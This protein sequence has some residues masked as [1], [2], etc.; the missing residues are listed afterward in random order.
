MILCHVITGLADGGAEA[1]LYRLCTFP[2]PGYRHI[3]VALGP[4]DK[5]APM[6][7][8]A[9]V[10]THCLGLPRGRLTLRAV[11]RMFKLL[12]QRK[13][14][15]VQTW[16]YHANL[17]GGVVARLA[18]CSN[19]VWGLHHTTLVSGTTGKSTQLV[20][21]LCARL[22][23][24][25]PSSIVACAQSARLVHEGYGY[26]RSKFV[27]V[28][29]GYETGKF[30]P[31][32][33]AG[34]AIRRELGIGLQA[35]VIGLVGRWHPDKDHPTLLAAFARV[36]GHF[37]DAQLLL[38]GT[39]CT[40]DNND[41]VAQIKDHGLDG[42]V[43]LLGRRSDVSAIM[44]AIDLHVLSSRS[45]AFPNVVAEAMACGTPCVVTDVGDASLIVGDTGWVV[46]PRNPEQLAGA[47]VKALRERSDFERWKARSHA[48]RQR[49]LNEFSLEKMVER[50]RRVWN[51][52]SA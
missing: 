51:S 22:S 15:V 44:N 25:V 5:Y 52:K 29:N 43:R 1:V 19:V 34:E 30:A 2:Q 14:D 32:A 36:V 17:V 45:E 7:R 3:V 8:A 31:D 4:E 35:P 41:L 9:G 42:S 23:R 46:P 6:L 33:A 18:G 38:A 48:A 10:E 24:R 28:P 27:V 26:D 49:I 16:M 47:I 21:R 12:R 20:N 11:I 37:S 50:Y 13:P 39:G 40:A